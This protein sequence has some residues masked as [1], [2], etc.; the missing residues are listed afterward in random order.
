MKR[1]R[2]SKRKR[3]TTPTKKIIKAI[4]AYLEAIQRAA[5]RDGH[6]AGVTHGREYERQKWL[7]VRADMAERLPVPSYHAAIQV[8]PDPIPLPAPKEITEEHRQAVVDLA[9]ARTFESEPWYV[10]L[11]YRITGKER[12]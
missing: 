4:P 6:A 2:S 8:E 3:P 10:T 12:V 1:R 5:Y 7:S 11:W 9:K